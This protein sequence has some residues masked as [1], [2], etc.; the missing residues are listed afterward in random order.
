MK[1]KLIKFSLMLTSSALLFFTSCSKDDDVTENPPK[2]DKYNYL[3]GLSI[4][5]TEN[6]PFHTVGSLES[7]TANITD[8]QEINGSDSGVPV[9]G[10]D[11]HVYINTASKLIK[12]KVE[13]NG[14][15]KEVASL[16]N[17]GISGGP[18]S[19]FLSKN[20]LLVS[21]GPRASVGGTFSYQIINTV[22][23]TE[24]SKGTI[25]LPVHE[26]DS[27]ATPS[28]FILKD[29]KIYIPF[30]QASSKWKG[31]DFASIAIYDAATLKFE[32]EIK[33]DKATGLGF[34]PVSSHASTENGD[35]YLIDSNTDWWGANEDLPS[36]IVRIKK[37]KSDFD[38]E[39]F[40]NLSEKFNGN[41]TGGM[42]YATKNKI[43]VQ[44]FRSDL[45]SKYKDYQGKHVIEY[46]AVD[47]A[48]GET[49]KLDIPLSKWPR[50][51][52]VS[53]GNG[54]VAIAA[55]TESEGNL[56]YIYD[57]STNKVSKGLTY[58]G[59]ESISSIT[60]IR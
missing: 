7:G 43:V 38:S 39:Y 59:T 24:E 30:Y 20:R 45:I 35:L 6:Y 42:V 3:L 57:V 22:T 29:N 40:L 11:G 28:L 49:T 54:K 32:K 33:T 8:A 25:T 13:E 51:A 1:N 10:K 27:K 55:N 44:V 23:M 18:V 14:I 56:I 46:Y 48:S 60:P 52:I 21:T 4:P 2:K 26:K 53:I 16:P 9:L 17:T 12:F 5:S 36:G 47:L 31:Y 15:L 50:H 19:T 34:S 37:G 58:N 41:H